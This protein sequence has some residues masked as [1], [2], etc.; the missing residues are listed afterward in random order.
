MLL[1]F[2]KDE[3]RRAHCWRNQLREINC[4]RAGGPDDLPN[5]L[6]KEY[7]DILAAPIAE[8]LNTSFSECKV[9]R[10]WKIAD[11]RP[12]QSFHDR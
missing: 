8:I 3:V 5:W 4:A 7:A 11:V 6:L 12:P 1:I 10:A 9:L 2:S